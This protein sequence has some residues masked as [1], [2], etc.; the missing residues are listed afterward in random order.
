MTRACI[1]TAGLAAIVLSGCCPRSGPPS[2]STRTP[3]PLKSGI[4]IGGTLWDMPVGGPGEIGSNTGNPIEAGSRIEV[5]G[6][7]IVV[8][9]EDGTQSLSP[10]GW[11]TQVA[12]KQ[13]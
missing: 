8:T 5:Y 13:D 12:F 7:F 11:Y 9:G 2:R 6:N 4:L 10:H 3:V 1:A